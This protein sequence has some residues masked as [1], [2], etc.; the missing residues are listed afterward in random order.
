MIL[1]VDVHGMVVDEAIIHIEKVIK[2]ADKDVTAI[3]VI[4]GYRGGN[5]LKKAIQDPNG[6]RSKRIA[7]RRYTMN[8]G[9]T[10]LELH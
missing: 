3:R 8:Q 1:D 4:H 10:I 6:I 7:R 5:A 9:E 2:K